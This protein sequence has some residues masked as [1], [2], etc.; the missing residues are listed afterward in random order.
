MALVVFFSLLLVSLWFPAFLWAWRLVVF[1]ITHS[2]H[3]WL[4][5]EWLLKAPV[6]F[7]LVAS[8]FVHQCGTDLASVHSLWW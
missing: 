2:T 3:L 7:H 1:L 8:L 6:S 5:P 4:I